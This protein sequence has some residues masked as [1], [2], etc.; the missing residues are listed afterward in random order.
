MKL[1]EDIEEGFNV[2][3]PMAFVGIGVTL[4]YKSMVLEANLL[5][6]DSYCTNR[7]I[8]RANRQILAIGSTLIALALLLYFLRE[9]QYIKYSLYALISAS[10]VWLWWLTRAWLLADDAG[11]NTKCK[12]Q[13]NGCPT[14]DTTGGTPCVGMQIK[15]IATLVQKLA[16]SLSF[17]GGVKIL[18][19]L[20]YIYK[21][22]DVAA[23]AAQKGQDYLEEQQVGQAAAQIAREKAIKEHRESKTPTAATARQLGF[24]GRKSSSMGCGSK[25]SNYKS[26]SMGCGSKKSNYKSSSMGGCGSKKSNYGRKSKFP[27]YKTSSA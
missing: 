24:P 8:Q 1:L 16:I 23:V 9:R 6:D 13:V 11:E 26:S 25:K 22:R 20:A 14:S 18:I 12:D 5:A 27:F 7:N 3:I 17:L 4:V 2:L 21:G 19:H 15:E 10:G